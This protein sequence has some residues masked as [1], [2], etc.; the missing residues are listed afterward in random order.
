MT[1]YT[2]TTG[3]GPLTLELWDKRAKGGPITE[4]QAVPR[5]LNG[6]ACTTVGNSAALWPT[7]SI[8]TTDGIVLNG[9][10]FR[11]GDAA[12]LR[13]REYLGPQRTTACLAVKLLMVVGPA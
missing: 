3:E 6:S 12:R 10:L 13:V 9:H 2:L 11:F 8:R 5:G 4:V 1:I 7:G